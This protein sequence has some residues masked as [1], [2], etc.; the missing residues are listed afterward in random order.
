VTASFPAHN[1]ELAE[2]LSRCMPCAGGEVRY[3]S[4]LD[5]STLPWFVVDAFAYIAYIA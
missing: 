3:A 1:G 2:S 5:T 4:L